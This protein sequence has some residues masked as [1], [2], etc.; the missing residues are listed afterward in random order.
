[1]KW[2]LHEPHTHTRRREIHRDC[3]CVWKE[4][5]HPQTTPTREMSATATFVR[6]LVADVLYGSTQDLLRVLLAA[7]RRVVVAA[8]FFAR[9]I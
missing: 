7:E 9:P 1:M 5:R 8:A 4:E 2:K 3:V 6:D